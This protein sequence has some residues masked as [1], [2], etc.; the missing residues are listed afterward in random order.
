MKGCVG[1]VLHIYEDRITIRN[2][3]SNRKKTFNKDHAYAVPPIGSFL[4]APNGQWYKMAKAGPRAATLAEIRVLPDTP[5][6]NANARA[7][8]LAIAD[9]TTEDTG[10]PLCFKRFICV[11]ISSFVFVLKF[12]GA[13]KTTEDAG[14]P[15][16]FKRSICVFIY[17]LVCVCFEILIRR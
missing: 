6:L 1:P 14:T 4:R 17:Q 8:A 5:I 16:R 2:Q 11:F 10:T 12:S 9:E 13:D 7:V 15:L 3:A